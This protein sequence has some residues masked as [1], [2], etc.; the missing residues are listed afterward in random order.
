MIL[1]DVVVVLLVLAGVDYLRRSAE[2]FDDIIELSEYNK[3]S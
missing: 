1:S 3:D 2:D